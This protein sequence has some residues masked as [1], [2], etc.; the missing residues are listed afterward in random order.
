MLNA[1]RKPFTSLVEEGTYISSQ[2]DQDNHRHKSMFCLPV[3]VTRTKCWNC[4]LQIK[5]IN[6]QIFSKQWTDKM[7]RMAFVILNIKL[8]IRCVDIFK[9]CDK[10]LTAITMWWQ[11]WQLLQV[12]S[13][14]HGDFPLGRL[15]SDM[16][17]I[18][19]FNYWLFH[20]SVAQPL[21]HHHLFLLWSPA[22]C[23]TGS[24]SVS[25]LLLLLLLLAVFSKSL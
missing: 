9:S 17:P 1:Y 22:Q 4:P 13:C 14:W 20:L 18:K 2:G 16:G 8:F 6:I 7:A 10:L 19:I 3:E 23:S 25:S 24:G 21:A 11:L 12:T 5:F 15:W